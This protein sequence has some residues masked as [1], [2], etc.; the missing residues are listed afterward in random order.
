M[1]EKIF[2]EKKIRECH[3]LCVYVNSALKMVHGALGWPS[4]GLGAECSQGSSCFSHM[5][6][7][8]TPVEDRLRT[9]AISPS[10]S[11]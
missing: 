8:L 7:K 6:K 10:C 2:N 9:T 4:R 1:S 5:K 3:S 11:L